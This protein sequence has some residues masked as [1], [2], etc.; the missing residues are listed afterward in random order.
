[1]GFP[2]GSAVKESACNERDLGLIPGLGRSPGEG[3][4][5]PLPQRIPWTVQSMASQRVRH[6]QVTFTFT[7]LFNHSISSQQSAS[8]GSSSQV[9][10]SNKGQMT[11]AHVSLE[12]KLELREHR[13]VV[14]FFF[15]Y[16]GQQAYLPAIPDRVTISVLQKT[17]YL[18]S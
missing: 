14:F 12:G 8:I 10:I 4:G 5:Y 16:T 6:N 3:N 9:S 7:S 2:G 11:F 13:F 1:M 18:Y 15:F 17:T